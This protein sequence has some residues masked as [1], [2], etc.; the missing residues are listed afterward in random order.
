MYANLKALRES[1]AMTQRDF[2]ASLNMAPNTYNN[3]ETGVR[4]P[5]S[6]FWIAVA[7]KYGVTIDY[8]MGFSNDPHQTSDPKK[9]PP[10]SGEAIK[11]GRDYD[12]LDHWGQKQVR[13]VTAIEKARVAE[14]QAKES[15]APP[16]EQPTPQLT[17]HPT[18]RRRPDGFVEIEVYDQPAAAGLG[19]YLD[20]PPSHMEQYPAELVPDRTDFGVLIS[21]DSMEPEIP[22]GS[23]VFV[24]S[25]ATL[26]AGEIGIFVLDG[27]S[28]CKTLAVDHDRRQVRLVSIN[29]AYADIPIG[30]TD[31]LRTLGR[32]LGHYAPRQWR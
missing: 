4:E 9:A 32:V 19:N 29:P 14:Q 21:G 5:R 2:A 17:D 16:A 1:L 15:S 20:T 22:D 13:S 6:D 8:L 10:M 26:A 7:E 18:A 28:Y 24:Q 12:T 31:E 27:K 3:Y 30:E 23:T 25:C 11:L